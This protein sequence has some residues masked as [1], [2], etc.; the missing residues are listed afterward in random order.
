MRVV[1]R[2][3]VEKLG[4]KGDLLEVADGYA[5][6]FLVP[7]GLAIVATKGVVDQAGAMRRNR[8]IRDDRDKEAAQELA[9]RLTTSPIQ[10][11]ARAGEGGKLFGSVTAA[12]I[13]A[14]VKEQTRVEIDRRKVTLAEPLKA[15]GPA[16]VPVQ[17]HA[18][19]TVA[20]AVEV[21]AE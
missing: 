21:V 9:T 1:L 13:V 12:D 4:R 17:L 16:E 15:L 3:D 8:Q 10:V 5:R 19:V 7:R 11:K 20:M 14:A 18:D 2:E 6:N